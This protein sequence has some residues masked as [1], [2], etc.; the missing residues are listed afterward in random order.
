MATDVVLGFDYGT[1]PTTVRDA[2]QDDARAIRG[3][4]IEAAGALMDIGE[5][6]N[7]AREA[8]PHGAWLPWLMTEA[9]MSEQWARD[10]IRVY[11]RFRS[12]RSI[13]QELNVA[14]PPTAIVRLASA[15]DAAC[16]DVLDRA[17]DGERLRVVDVEAVIK[18][19]RQQALDG[20]ANGASEPEVSKREGGAGALRRLADQARDELVPQ[21]VGRA[22]AVLDVLADA[23]QRLAMGGKVTAESL[24]GLRSE[25]QWLVDGLEQATQRRAPGQAKLVHQTFL[26][27]APMDDGPWVEAAV[28]LRSISS[29]DALAN[30]LKVGVPAFVD[31]GVRAL[32]QALGD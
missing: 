2:L 7:R 14:L 23:E 27:R 3:R 10:C 15:P 8:L 4:L 24:K 1:V 29:S 6:L 32:R 11:T 21:I 19:H 25:A 26:D 22:Q 20:R 30:A 17:R 5:R 9:G 18:Q 31:R 16:N 28:F 13:F 12:D